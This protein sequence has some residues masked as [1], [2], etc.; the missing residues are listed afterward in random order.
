V[1]ARRNEEEEEEEGKEDEGSGAADQAEALVAALVAVALGQTMLFLSVFS[2]SSVS[3]L[4]HVRSY[5]LC[6]AYVSPLSLSHLFSPVF[7][8]L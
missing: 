6:F 4:P 5:F 8:S 7:L 3:A 1:E 2:L